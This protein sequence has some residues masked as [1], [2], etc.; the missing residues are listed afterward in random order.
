MPDEMFQ[1][2][3]SPLFSCDRDGFAIVDGAKTRVTGFAG[4]QIDPVF[5]LEVGP[6]NVFEQRPVRV[7]EHEDHHYVA[8]ECEGGETVHLDFYDLKAS[9]EGPTGAWVYRGP[10]DEGNDGLGFMPAH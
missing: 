6:G 7:L 3:E 2:P 9:K 4:L 1:L 8:V 10:L 5:T